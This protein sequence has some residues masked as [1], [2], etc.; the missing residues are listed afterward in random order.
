MDKNTFFQNVADYI[1]EHYPCPEL[2]N[3]ELLTKIIRDYYKNLFPYLKCNAVVPMNLVRG[4][5]KYIMN[6]RNIFIKQKQLK[7]KYSKINQKVIYTYL[8][9]KKTN[10]Y[11]YAPYNL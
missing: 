9:N 7:D 4:Y 3:D 10:N 11:Y 8:Y 1:L 2:I 6:C 5:K